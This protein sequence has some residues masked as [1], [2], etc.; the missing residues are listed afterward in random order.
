MHIINKY[1]RRIILIVILFIFVWNFSPLYLFIKVGNI[2]NSKLF[3][4]KNTT[5]SLPKDWMVSVMSSNNSQLV[6]INKK[7]ILKNKLDIHDITI[8]FKKKGNKGIV[9][10]PDNRWIHILLK[11]KKYTMHNGINCLYKIY[12]TNNV[13]NNIYIPKKNAILKFHKYDNDIPKFI[14]DFCQE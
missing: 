7:F 10:F 12:R 5:I 1:K 6:Y 9:E 13:I 4:D 11:D 3:I 2:L 8:Y 14:D